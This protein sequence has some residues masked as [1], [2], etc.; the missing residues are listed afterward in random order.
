MRLP[1]H[2]DFVNARGTLVIV[3]TPMMHSWSLFSD[4]CRDWEQHPFLMCSSA[5][6]A[7][8]CSGV[9]TIT[10]SAGNLLYLVLG[11]SLELIFVL[12]WLLEYL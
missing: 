10:P 12:I 9:A 1:G 3:K 2:Q 6:V 8:L 7:W 5:M 11:S 4:G